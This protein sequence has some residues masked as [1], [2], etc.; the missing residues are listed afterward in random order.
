MDLYIIPFYVFPGF[1]GTYVNSGY[2]SFN[3]NATLYGA[4]IA[5]AY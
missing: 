5:I 3:V 2:L 4:T 1:N